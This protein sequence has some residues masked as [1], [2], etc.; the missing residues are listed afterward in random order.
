MTTPS[1]DRS[2]Q[3][4]GDFLLL[5]RL[6]Q[7]G[8]GQVYLARQTSLNRQ[9]A[10]KLLRPELAANETALRRFHAE[11]KAV[12]HITHA[13]IVQ[14]YA[15]GEI[16]G[17]HFMALEYVEG[18]TLRDFL[19]KKGP[20]SLPFALS[21][22]RQVAAALQRAGERGF[23]HRDIKPENILL[24]RQGEAKVTDFGVSRCFDAPESLSL[25][26]TGLTLGTPLYMSP[27]QVQGDPVD[28]RSDIYSFGIT[29]YHMFTGSP[30]F[31]GET[32]YQVAL[33]HVHV[34]PVSL[35]QIRPD[36]PAELSAIITKMMAK[37]PAERYQTAR[38]ILRDL[39][40]IQKG[41]ALPDGEI[42]VEPIEV[43]VLNVPSSILSRPESADPAVSPTGRWRWLIATMI[44]LVAMGGGAAAA[45]WQR[46]ATD[47][48]A[49]SRADSQAISQV[50][51]PRVWLGEFSEPNEPDPSSLGQLVS[52]IRS[53]QSKQ[54]VEA[55]AIIQELPRANGP[56]RLSFQLLG[57]AIL[58]AHRDH[59][60]R[61]ME[62]FDQAASDKDKVFP[63]AIRSHF[64]LAHGVAEA[65][66][67]NRDNLFAR[68]KP[69]DP[70]WERLLAPMGGTR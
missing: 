37:A 48:V 14:V 38:E 57:L 32:P 67:R 59:A 54:L 30:P 19:T 42:P 28:P 8:M 2:G 43:P 6:G 26:Q 13:N 11:A 36:L 60:E 53:I 52:A 66:R 18:Q 56:N 4:I 20:P 12:A 40:R 46:Q 10:L 5:R 22:M 50:L 63:N 25:T 55:E 15:I 64:V 35:Q 45:W 31:R 65:L 70:R 9:V 68:G 16:D 41:E 62:L 69:F 1:D 51:H 34:D 29:S 23:V 58:E 24:T 61:S 17:Q 39:D 7:G 3:T 44:I 33:Q 21:I 27:E 47:T 49:D